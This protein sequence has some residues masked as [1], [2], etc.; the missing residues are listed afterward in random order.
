M[1]QTVGAVV[2]DS[3]PAGPPVLSCPRACEE[4]QVVLGVVAATYYTPAVLGLLL[5]T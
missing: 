3:R 2:C 1:C 4:V 5:G